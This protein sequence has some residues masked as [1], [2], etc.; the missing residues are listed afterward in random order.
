MRPFTRDITQ[1]YTQSLSYWELD[2]YI[3]PTAEMIPPSQKVLKVGKVLYG[4]PESGLHWYLTYTDNRMSKIG[5]ARS[6]AD[7]CLL[8]KHDGKR[9][10]GMV[11]LQVDDSLIV[12]CKNF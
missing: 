11:I 2:V 5:K 7:P 8:Y 9:L 12:R 10:G 3:R 6:H 4:I 1:T